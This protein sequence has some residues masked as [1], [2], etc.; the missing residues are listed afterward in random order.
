VKIG[1]SA[2]EILSTLTL[3]YGEYAVNTLSVFEWHRQFKEG[4]EGVQE[5]LGSVRPKH[6]KKDLNV[7][8]LQ[9]LVCSD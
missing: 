1:K 6:K 7:D 2:S 8:R 3:A 9:T 4:Q 5:D